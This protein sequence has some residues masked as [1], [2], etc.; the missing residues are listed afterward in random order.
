[1]NRESTRDRKNGFGFPAYG[2]ICRLKTCETLPLS[3]LYDR[4]R[5]EQ[6]VL[7]LAPTAPNSDGTLIAQPIVAFQKFVT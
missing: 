1:V 5:I 2:K 7:Q 3:W 6:T 4:F